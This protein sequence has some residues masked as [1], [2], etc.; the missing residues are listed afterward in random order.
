MMGLQP[1]L[2]RFEFGLDIEG[3]KLR[4]ASGPQLSGRFTFA[5]DLSKQT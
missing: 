4:A 1:F 5:L 3:S 2:V